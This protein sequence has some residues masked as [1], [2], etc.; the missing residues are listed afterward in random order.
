MKRKNC[1]VVTL[2]L[3][4]FCLSLALLLTGC[5]TIP[6]DG[7]DT[8]KATEPE[9][10]GGQV[11]ETT[12]PAETETSSYPGSETPA[13]EIPEVQV[14]LD[15]L[16]VPARSTQF[17]MTFA[18]QALSLC[19]GH[20]ADRQREL[21]S[22]AGFEVLLQKNYDKESSDPSHTSAFTVAKRTV[23]VGGTPR[24]LL[25]VAIRGTVAGE[26]YSNFDFAPSH[27]NDA[28]FAENF[29]LAAEDI[30]TSVRPLAEAEENPLFLVCGHSRGGACANLLG[31]LLNALYGTDSVYTYTFATPATI[32][33]EDVG[34]DC[35]NIFNVINPS[36]LVTKVP[37][38]V[39]GYRRL[40]Q[41]IPLPADA[42]VVVRVED[43]VRTLSGIAPTISQ[44][45]EERHSLTS[46]GL[47]E[48]GLATFEMMLTMVRS[49]LSGSESGS[50]SDPIG[51]SSSASGGFDLSAIPEDNDFGPLVAL[52]KNA[53]ADGGTAAAKALSQHLPA[54]YLYLMSLTQQQ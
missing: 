37:L 50:G 51:G 4:L 14:P 8:S 42:E 35:G 41:D 11:P 22:A 43:V 40:G 13:P 25:V 5:S 44:Y 19:S 7:S 54:L 18:M 2:S 32:R 52:L 10:D 24:V 46:P 47:S 6:G 31:M 20:T 28:A 33:T 12:T 26:W 36:D 38:A 53:S 1:G 23:T 15:P 30:L 17:S 21:M 49:M 39:W 9:S 34:T 16:A 48:Y 3:R 45:Y 29:L 27:S